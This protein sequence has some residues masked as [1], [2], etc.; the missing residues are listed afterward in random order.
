M[1]LFTPIYMK[2]NL[3]LKQQ[4][5]ALEKVAAIADPD[6]LFRIALSAPMTAVATKA[7]E[8]LN[9]SNMLRRVAWESGNLSVRRA[10]AEKLTDAE[11]LISLAGAEPELFDTCLRRLKA[12]GDKRGL[13][14]LFIE[15]TV[16]DETRSINA[17]D[18][19]YG[20]VVEKLRGVA[21]QEVIEAVARGA[22]K[23][24]IRAGAVKLLESPK[25]LAEI[26]KGDRDAVVRR[27]AINS[28]NFTDIGTLAGIA[29]NESLGL[30]AYRWSAALRLTGL[31]PERAVGPLVMLLAKTGGAKEDRERLQAAVRFLEERY[32]NAKGE[33]RERIAALK[34]GQ[35]GLNWKGP[36]WHEDASVHFDIAR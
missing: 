13:A 3:N 20:R 28:P 36:C 6:R 33:E 10:A 4:R 31:A 21:D 26:A 27:A 35:Y 25:A 30:D 22:R 18:R 5:K 7:V 12:L 23:A 19:E 32:R 2:G 34:N 17:I 24:K 15:Y 8:V 11:A 1:G 14:R 29:G 9:D 16:R